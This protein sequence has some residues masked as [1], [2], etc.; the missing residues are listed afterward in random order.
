MRLRTLSIGSLGL[1]LGLG[2]AVLACRRPPEPVAPRPQPQPQPQDQPLHPPWPVEGAGSGGGSAVT[3]VATNPEIPIDPAKPMPAQSLSTNATLEL[4]KPAS[5]IVDGRADVF[6]A[7]RPHPE[8]TRGGRPPVLVTLVPGGGYITF[9]TVKGVVGCVAGA[10]TPPDGGNCAGG[11]TNISAADGI[12][13]IIDHQHTQFLVG[14]FLGASTSSRA[15][16]TLDFSEKA[17]GES[18]AELSPAIG[19]TFYIGD[20]F[21]RSGLNQRFVIPSGATR[22]YLGFADAFGFQGVPG[23]YGDNTGG[24][25]VTL[26]QAK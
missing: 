2:V 25:A 14:V 8:E 24:L 22:F 4:R 18:F 9:S 13:G 10:T 3:P 12:S 23:A 17:Q 11:D 15:P 19:Q 21:T 16:A 6:S 5:V 7:G 20:G 26:T 1:G